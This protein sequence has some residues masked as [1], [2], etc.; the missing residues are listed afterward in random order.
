VFVVSDG[1]VNYVLPFASN[2]VELP[3]VPKVCFI[4]LH[5]PNWSTNDQMNSQA[6]I[7]KFNSSWY[8]CKSNINSSKYCH[9]CSY[10]QGQGCCLMT[11]FDFKYLSTLWV[12][13]LGTFRRRKWRLKMLWL[14][15]RFRGSF[16]RGLSGCSKN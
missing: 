6:V 13:N 3:Y 5:L 2:C 7:M 4:P 14:A 8:G 11:C 12:L 1:L 9:F 16:N 10:W 15:C